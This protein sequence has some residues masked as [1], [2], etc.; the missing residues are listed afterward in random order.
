MRYLVSL[1][2]LTFTVVV[3]SACPAFGDGVVRDGIGA[4]STARGGTNL[5]YSDNAVIILDNPAGMSGAP[6][7]G[8]WEVGLDTVIC[9][10]HYSDPDNDVFNEVKGFP[11]GM[12]GLVR[13]LDGTA[14][15]YGLG[16]F[17]PAG[18][19]AEFDMVNPHTGPTRYK[20]LGALGK[21][22][23]A[24]SYQVTDRLSIGAAIGVGIGHVELEGPFYVQTGP[25][26]GAPTLLDMQGTDTAV[27]GNIGLQYALTPQTTIGV[28]YTEETRFLFDARSRATLITPGGLVGSDFDT[29]VDLVWP[30]SVGVGIKHDLCPC[31]RISADVIWYDWSHAFNR[32][33][34]VFSNPSNPIVGGL[35]PGGSISDSLA[36]DWEDSVSLRFGYEWDS[37]DVVTWRVG[38]VYHDAPVPDA[39]LNPFVD[40]VLE[41]AFALG[42]SRHYDDAS[43]NLAYQYSFGSDRSVGDSA[44]VGDDF[45]NSTFD[46][47][48]HWVSLSLLVPY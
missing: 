45:S 11:S 33:D 27:V 21:V 19:S 6:D 38:Y 15:S 22:L 43:L 44:L 36:M 48:A 32:L 25:L 12:F 10:L 7:C 37:S 2:T 8:F 18:F 24:L 17:A 47:D 40:G 28:S 1:C 3:L 34:F 29:Q 5:G 26:A 4:I 20:S 41:H 42:V 14:W 35:I 16:V 39:T 31:Q 13:H 46:A 9:D 23:P 30:R